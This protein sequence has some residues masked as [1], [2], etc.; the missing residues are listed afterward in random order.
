MSEYDDSLVIMLYDGDPLAKLIKEYYAK[1]GQRR[2]LKPE[3]CFL[4]RPIFWKRAKKKRLKLAGELDAL[5]D[6]IKPIIEERYSHVIHKCWWKA[7]VWYRQRGATALLVV[8][9]DTDP[10]EMERKVRSCVV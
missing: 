2:R 9:Y 7:D 8:N 1:V 6:E 5:A 3:Q 10:D 4:T